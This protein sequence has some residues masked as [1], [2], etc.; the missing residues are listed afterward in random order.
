MGRCGFYCFE[1]GDDVFVLWKRGWERHGHNLMVLGRSEDYSDLKGAGAAMFAA[2][3]CSVNKFLFLSD[4]SMNL[5]G[6]SSDC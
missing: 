4:I 1:G 6:A 3:H 5:E 2:R